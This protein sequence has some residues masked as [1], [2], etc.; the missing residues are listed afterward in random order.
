MLPGLIMWG[1][2]VPYK[3]SRCSITCRHSFQAS[4]SIGTSKPVNDKLLTR[5]HGKNTLWLTG[6]PSW[7]NLII[8]WKSHLQFAI[9]S[10]QSCSVGPLSGSKTRWWNNG[11]LATWTAEKG[12]GVRRWVAPP[13]LLRSREHGGTGSG[14]ICSVILVKP[15]K[16]ASAI[17][18][19]VTTYIFVW[20]LNS[21]IRHLLLK[22]LII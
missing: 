2:P 19:H 8:K 5:P 6:T 18:K 15:Y 4:L 9:Y 16:R 10:W 3:H 13:R 1:Q 20:L 14:G 7:L 11:V 21:F 22:Y 17:A 12:C